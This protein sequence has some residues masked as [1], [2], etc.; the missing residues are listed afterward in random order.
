L[1]SRR[2]HERNPHNYLADLQSEGPLYQRVGPL[3]DFLAQWRLNRDEQIEG[4]GESQLPRYA[5][6][7]RGA[8]RAWHRG[9]GGRR[10]DDV[11]LNL[12]KLV[13]LPRDK[14]VTALAPGVFA[15][16]N[17]QATVVLE[18]AFWGLLLPATVHGRVSDIWRSYVLERVMW[19]VGGVLAFTSASS[20]LVE[21]Q[22]Q[23]LREAVDGVDIGIGV[24]QVLLHHDLVLAQR[25]LLGRP[26]VA[27]GVDVLDRVER[28]ATRPRRGRSVPRVRIPHARARIVVRGGG[29]AT[30]SGAETA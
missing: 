12:T 19:E 23:L 28:I 18:G 5:P 7:L 6:A 21:V 24:G 30:A 20:S 9:A 25:Q 4:E 27:H 11:W 17:A 16:F 1:A 2:C 13:D 29:M 10:T 22:R 8:L 14:R 3:V 15:P 26:H